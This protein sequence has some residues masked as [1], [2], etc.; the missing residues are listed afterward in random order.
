VVVIFAPMGLRQEDHEFQS[1]MG[2]IA[3]SCLKKKRRK[4]RKEG[5][6]EGG[7]EE[8]KKKDLVKLIHNHTEL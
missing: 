5:R 1:S 3:K 7:R 4:G 6:N 8:G 2:Y